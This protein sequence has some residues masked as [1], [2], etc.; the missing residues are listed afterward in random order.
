MAESQL[1][2][3]D[4]AKLW[5]VYTNL[6]LFYNFYPIVQHSPRD[7]KKKPAGMQAKK[8]RN[9]ADDIDELLVKNLNSI[10][11]KSL[12]LFLMRKDILDSE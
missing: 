11:E 10:Q 1:D 6:F 4:T 2:S 5:Y 3:S 7:T 8:K 9:R 12:K